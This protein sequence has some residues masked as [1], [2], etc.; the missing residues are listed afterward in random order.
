MCT[1]LFALRLAQTVINMLLV[2]YGNR[3]SL[4][5]HMTVHVWGM[6]APAAPLDQH[7]ALKFLAVTAL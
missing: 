4:V 1:A 6:T 2:S 5:S 7:L 3:H